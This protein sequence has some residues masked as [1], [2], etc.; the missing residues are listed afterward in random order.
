MEPLRTLAWA[1][2]RTVREQAGYL[3]HLKIQEATAA[4]P[5]TPTPVEAA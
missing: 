4:L 5:D 1:D 3:L 2:H